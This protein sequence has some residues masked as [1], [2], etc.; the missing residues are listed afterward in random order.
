VLRVAGASMAGAIRAVT[1]EV[2][3]DPRRGALIAYGGAG[4]LFAS[5]LAEAL[6][7][8]T[9]VVPNYA[10]NFSA[11][12]LLEQDVVRSAALTIVAPLDEAGIRRADETLEGLFTQLEERLDRR[13]PGTVSHEAE[14][15]LRYPG[16]EYT[17]T[18][19]VALDDSRIAETPDAITARFAA[20]YERN[21]GHSFDVG[22]DILSVRAIE[23]TE[24]P[25]PSERARSVSANGA[26]RARAHV[27]AYS[28]RADE[29]CDFAVLERDS[30][31][32]GETFDGPAIVLETTTTT[33]VDVGLRGVVH[34]SGALILT[35]VK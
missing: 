4:P 26:P 7:I 5:L 15:D 22:V 31:G 19:A 18:I 21:Y 30:L 16:Q 12:G 33:Y 3:E 23:R 1:I 10:G 8:E 24:L 17:L 29:W 25:R 28:F 14:L 27:S 34:E 35:D 2:G 20:A 32:R 13:L 9:I 11:W 6:G